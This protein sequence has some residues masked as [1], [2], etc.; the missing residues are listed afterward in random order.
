LAE[1]WRKRTGHTLLNRYG[2]TEAN[3]IASH[4]PENRMNICSVGPPLPGVDIRIRDLRNGSVLA[5]NSTGSLE[6]HGPGLF[7]GYWQMPEKTKEALHDDGFFR[8]GDLARL[9][10]D[11]SLHIEGRTQDLIISGGMNV[12]PAEV[13]AAINSHPDTADSVVIGVPHADYGESVIAVVLPREGTRVGVQAL[14]A[15]IRARISGY[16]CPKKIMLRSSLP[17]N[18]MEKVDRNFLRREYQD[19]FDA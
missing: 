10:A 4:T 14:Q 5:D 8:T 1:E 6:I 16:K 9:D 3:I 2:M 15:H 7:S 17:R 19:C 13:E 12:Y 11:G 18:A